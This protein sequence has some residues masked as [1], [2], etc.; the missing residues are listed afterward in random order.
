[1]EVAFNL[2]CYAYGIFVGYKILPM[3]VKR[4]EK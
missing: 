3:I 4:G 2:L 1:M